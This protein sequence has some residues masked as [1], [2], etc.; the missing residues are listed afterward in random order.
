MAELGFVRNGSARQLR[1]GSSRTVAYIMLDTANP[2]FTDVARGIE[3]AAASADLLLFSCNSDHLASRERS[4]LDRLEQQRV[5][6]V[7][8]TPVTRPAN[9]LMS[10][11]ARHPGRDRRPYPGR[12][13]A[14]FSISR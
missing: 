5:Q 3:D 14:L 13:D 12:P 10:S 1:L 6:G 9:C 2:F 7:L 11:P 4:Y 8:I